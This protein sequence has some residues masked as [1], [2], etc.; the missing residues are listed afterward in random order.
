M[1]LP[2]TDIIL[3]GWASY[4][5]INEICGGIYEHDVVV[6]ADHFV[7]PNDDSIH[8]QNIENLWMRLKR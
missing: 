3:D 8:T 1:I 7:D 5:H 6:H 4:G 2:G